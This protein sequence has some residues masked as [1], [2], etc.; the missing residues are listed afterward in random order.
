MRKVLIIG[1]NGYIGK[2]LKKNLK[3][4]FKL[5]LPS[6]SKDELD[7]LKIKSIKKK[8][9]KNL[10]AIINLSGQNTINKKILRKT[11]IE[12]NKNLIN[13]INT[14]NKNILYIFISSVLVYGFK[15]KVAQEK[16]NCKPIN[17]YGKLKLEA[18]KF[19]KMNCSNFRILRLCNVYGENINYG[20]FKK[21]FESLIK[22]KKI[23]F[24]NL[25][26]KRNLIHVKDV[27]KSIE[28]SLNRKKTKNKL[29]INIGNKNL[30]LLTILNFIKKISGKNI[31]FVNKRISIKKDSSQMISNKELLKIKNWEFQDIKKT[32]S[33]I[34]EKNAKY[35]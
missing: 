10:Y 26:T 23:Y 22:K 15:N 34:I 11:I 32:L 9:K 35:F 24:S 1:S 13:T 3:N 27:V 6:H 17:S 12:G 33:N 19:I 29:I 5:I 4:K 21:I 30:S 20:F 18:E 31:N 7:V 14:V 8:I 16:S 25:E 28:L 2:Y